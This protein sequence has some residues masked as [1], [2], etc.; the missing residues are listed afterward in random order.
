MDTFDAW[1]KGS[2][3]TVK[4]GTA[5][6][7]LQACGGSLQATWI[8]SQGHDTSQLVTRSPLPGFNQLSP[9]SVGVEVDAPVWSALF[10]RAPGDRPVS[11]A[12]S[13]TPSWRGA[14][15]CVTLTW[16]KS[17]RLA[18]SAPPS[19]CA[20]FIA[21]LGAHGVT[22]PGDVASLLST[23]QDGASAIGDS[24]DRASSVVGAAGTVLAGTTAAGSAAGA[25]MSTLGGVGGALATVGALQPAFLSASRLLHSTFLS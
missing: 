18:L 12:P 23:A 7:Q 25:V 13:A 11:V 17:E 1:W 15:G 19:Q 6:V 22:V 2:S 20:Q 3:A 4:L 8:N 24:A 14:L 5:R 16:P 9:I 10:L 21:W